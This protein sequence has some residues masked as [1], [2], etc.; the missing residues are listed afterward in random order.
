MYKFKFFFKAIPSRT[1]PPP[2]IKSFKGLT[3]YDRQV[4]DLLARGWGTPPPYLHPA[5]LRLFGGQLLGLS[6][7]GGEW[8]TLHPTIASSAPLGLLERH[9]PG[10]WR[11]G[12]GW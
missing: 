9:L 3:M 11:G 10:L 5:P 12:R 7:L 8:G 6:V 2:L 1:P 4:L